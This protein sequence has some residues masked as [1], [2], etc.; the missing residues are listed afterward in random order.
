[1][2]LSKTFLKTRI[3]RLLD[4]LIFVQKVL[5]VQVLRMLITRKGLYTGEKFKQIIRKKGREIGHLIF[6]HDLTTLTI[7]CQLYFIRIYIMRS[8]LA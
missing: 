1:M 2:L 4:G 6:D 3:Q 5:G 8:L 7:W